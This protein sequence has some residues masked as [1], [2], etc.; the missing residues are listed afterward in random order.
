M[1]LKQSH[2][3]NTPDFWDKNWENSNFEDAVRFCKLNPLRPLF[4]KYSH[5]G[6]LMLEG[7][8]GM[9]HYLAYYSARNWRVIGLDFTYY[10]LKELHE[11][12]EHLMLCTGNVARLPFADETFDIYY[13]GGVVEHFEEGANESLSEARRVLKKKGVLLISVPYFSPLRKILMP[14]KKKEWRKVKNEIVDS[15]KFFDDKTFFQYAYSLREFERKLNDA[16]LKVIEKM[17][18]GIL[19]GLYDIPLLNP[20]GQGEVS[21][22][23]KQNRLS[24]SDPVNISKLIEE[25]PSSLL[26]R[27]VV[28]E[29]STIP[30]L[31]I[32]VEFMRWFAANMMMYVCTRK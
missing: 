10:S 22:G 20:K 18:C 31:G 16:G 25:E 28:S 30:I 6:S 15:K 23:R 14:L 29:D 3:G 17:G 4:E 2:A 11:R 27:L 12:Q 26:K 13:S 21:N 5:A 24:K 8:C 9:G 32:G 1:Y 7:G 19:W